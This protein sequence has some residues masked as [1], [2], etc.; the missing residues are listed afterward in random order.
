M[1]T[2][3]FTAVQSGLGEIFEVLSQDRVQPTPRSTAFRG[4]EHHDLGGFLRRLSSTARGGLQS[5]IQDRVQQHIVEEILVSVSAFKGLSQDRDQQRI[6]E[7]II[8]LLL[9][10]WFNFTREVCGIDLVVPCFLFWL[11]SSSMVK[12]G[13]F[14]RVR[15]GSSSTSGGMFLGGPSGSLPG[16]PDLASG[17]GEC[18]LLSGTPS[19][20]GLGFFWLLRG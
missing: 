6:V 16:L 12:C 7:L 8:V 14:A 4:A 10:R 11:L 15:R 9:R 19:V 13:V 5:L 2:F 18:G 20:E 3:R 1:S 17:S